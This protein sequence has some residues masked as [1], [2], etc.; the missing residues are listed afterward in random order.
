M[1]DK[2][3]VKENAHTC[4]QIITDLSAYISACGTDWVL[5]E[6][7]A[8][9][10]LKSCWERGLGSLSPVANIPACP[11][12]MAAVLSPHRREGL[13]VEVMTGP[14]RVSWAGG[15][16]FP[17]LLQL[18]G[19]LTPCSGWCNT[20]LIRTSR[21]IQRRGGWEVKLGVWISRL[22]GTHQH[23]YNR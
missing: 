15:D 14:Y 3:F 10:D 4:T 12:Y 23:V 22:T 5:Q 20:F 17:S 19:S 1:I 13:T 8:W 21:S 6:G 11:H 16:L 2:C 18:P 9:L 7:W